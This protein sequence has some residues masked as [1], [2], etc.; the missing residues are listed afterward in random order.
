LTGPREASWPGF[1]AVKETTVANLDPN[2]DHPGWDNGLLFFGE[3]GASFMGIPLH[4][5]WASG[6]HNL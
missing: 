5:V 1:T 3:Q 2:E 6:E 4:N